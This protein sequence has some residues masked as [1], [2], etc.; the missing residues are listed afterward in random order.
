MVKFLFD[1]GYFVVG[2][3]TGTLIGKYGKELYY[4]FMAKDEE[5]VEFEL[6]NYEII[7]QEE[8]ECECEDQEE[9]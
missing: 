7:C 3:A 8:D 2:I 6:K 5:D 4:K 1:I 9:S